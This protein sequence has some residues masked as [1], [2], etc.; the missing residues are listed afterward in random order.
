MPTLCAWPHT[1]LAPQLHAGVEWRWLVIAAWLSLI[2]CP[3]GFSK[4]E[5]AWDTVGTYQS[6]THT[7]IPCMNLNHR[8][9]EPM[10]NSSPFSLRQTTVGNILSSSSED[11]RRMQWEAL[12]AQSDDQFK[13]SHPCMFFLLP[14]MFSEITCQNILPT[15]RPFLVWC[16]AF[17]GNSG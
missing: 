13:K 5:D 11:S 17:S 12:I 2:V 6:S 3:Q 14:L 7:Y 16:S 1:F 15:H 9:P 10:T 4:S 8:D